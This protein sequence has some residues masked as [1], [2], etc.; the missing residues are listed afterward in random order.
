[1][2]TVKETEMATATAIN[3]ETSE[4]A[5]NKT[6]CNDKTTVVVVVATMAKEAI[7]T[8]KVIQEGCSLTCRVVTMEAVEAAECTKEEDSIKP[9]VDRISR[10]TSKIRTTITR[11]LN[12]NSLRAVETVLTEISV[13]LPTDPP[14]YR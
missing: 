11:Q 3:S 7:T 4:E 12:A 1:M 8:S 10:A 9:K 6:E 2:E 5:T 14:N 13:L